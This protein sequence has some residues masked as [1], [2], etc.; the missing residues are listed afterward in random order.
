MNTTGNDQFYEH[1]WT[2]VDNAMFSI[3]YLN[4]AHIFHV[5]PSEDLKIVSFKVPSIL[6][7]SGSP[8]RALFDNMTKELTKNVAI[9]TTHCFSRKVPYKVDYKTFSMSQLTEPVV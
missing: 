9:T 3:R 5:C 6:H 4:Y 2:W 1:P 8:N 7:V